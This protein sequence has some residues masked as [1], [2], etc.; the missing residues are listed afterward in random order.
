MAV[1]F[2]IR[3][4]SR[5]GNTITF[6]VVALNANGSID[7]GYT[8][9]FELTGFNFSGSGTYEFNA[10]HQGQRF[11][12]V[13]IGNPNSLALIDADFPGS[14]ASANLAITAPVGTFGPVY[15]QETGDHL[16]IGNVGNEAYY[17]N[18]G[19]D[20][21][22]F[23]QGGDDFAS[24]GGGD[25][26]FYF[27]AAYTL[28]DRVEGGAGTRDQIALQGNYQGAFGPG[29]TLGS[30]PGVE[31]VVLLPGN[32]T[33]F[34][35]F[36]GSLYN[37]IVVADGNTVVSENRLTIQANTLQAGELFYFDGSATSIDYIIYGGRGFNGLVT[38]SGNDGFFF[39]DGR[40]NNDVV[41]GNGGSDQLGL[42]G[43]YTGANAISFGGGQLLD[44][45]FIVLLS[46]SDNRFGASGGTVGYDL[47]MH[48]GNVAAGQRM[49]IQG[50]TL[51]AGET[52]TFNGAAELDGG[53]QIFSGRGDDVLSGGQG[54]DEIWGGAGADTITG[55]GGAD[56]LR[57]GAGN[58]LFV[59]NFAS[60][61]T[62]S[63]RD[64]IADFALGDIIRLSG[65]AANSGGGSFAFI[66]SNDPTG[67]R[68]VQVVQFEAAAT[69]NVYIDG[70][71]IPDLVINV[72]LLG[73]HALGIGDF[74]GV[75]VMQHPAQA[76]DGVL[77]RAH[78][79]W[80]HDVSGGVLYRLGDPDLIETPDALHALPS[81]SD[82]LL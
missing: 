76:F 13:T 19:N 42:Q 50:N 53:F 17:G 39:G 40:F 16:I 70:D 73:G 62:D 25:D 74:S 11:I 68:Q 22:M 14:R 28:A 60:D 30:M 44:M 33:R 61:S 12:T 35:D 65:L 48:D 72:T 45:E 9:P 10:N 81:T 20:L 34:G 29:V 31:M 23:Q 32:D 59:Y 63:A 57:G 56:V 26:G 54:A 1:K 36:S 46:A 41:D 80:D 49:I 18:D 51:K 3:N 71:A 8:G 21:F 66:G 27:G 43:N 15:L 75:G 78:K 79:L 67:A 2:G 58:D 47:T 52:L 5:S 38:G 82:L 7:T 37:Y 24:G 6:T 64:E 4:Y 77:D 55:N 69:V